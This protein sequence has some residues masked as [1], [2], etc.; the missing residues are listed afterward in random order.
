MIPTRPNSYRMRSRLEAYG[1]LVEHGVQMGLCEFIRLEEKLEVMRPA[2][3][4]GDEFRYRIAVK[5]RHGWVGAI[6]DTNMACL[7]S[8]YPIDRQPL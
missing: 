3:E 2:F 1:R 7:L 5:R 4:L 8:V 6:Y